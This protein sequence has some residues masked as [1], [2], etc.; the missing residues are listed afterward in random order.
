MTDDEIKGV[1]AEREEILR[2]HCA[3]LEQQ[4]AVIPVMQADIKKYAFERDEALAQLDKHRLF[5]I[6][7]TATMRDHIQEQRTALGERYRTIEAQKVEIE[8][9]RAA[10]E[11]FAR[12]RAVVFAAVNFAQLGSEPSI[13]PEGS[14]PVGIGLTYADLERAEAA[15]AEPKGTKR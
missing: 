3:E 12:A 8:Q 13:Q 9:Q 14:T 5:D 7:R 11:P 4:N 15:L 6:R 1:I 10:L 2:D